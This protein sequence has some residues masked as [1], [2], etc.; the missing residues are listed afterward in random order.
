MKLHLNVPAGQID[1]HSGGN[2]QA[3]CG[4]SGSGSTIQPFRIGNPTEWQ[5]QKTCHPAVNHG[6]SHEE[7]EPRHR[8]SME[9]EQC[10]NSQVK[11]FP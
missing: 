7:T 2:H 8:H 10:E 5:Q 11:V 4:G 3:Y 9:P 1:Q 6:V